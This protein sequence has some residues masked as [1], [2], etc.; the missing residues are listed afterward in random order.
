MGQDAHHRDKN[1]GDGEIRLDNYNKPEYGFARFCYPEE[2]KRILKL[3]YRL[4]HMGR[5]SDGSE[6]FLKIRIQGRYLL[7]LSVQKDQKL[8]AHENFHIDKQEE[9]S[10]H[11]KIL[12]KRAGWNQS[13]EDF[14]MLVR[15][16]RQSYFLA[17]I[18][19]NGI[20]I[21]LG[22]GALIDI[23]E[24]ISWISMVLVHEEVRRQGIAAS[25]MFHC[26]HHARSAAKN[27][28]IGLDATPAGMKLYEQLG[29]IK[30]FP[31]CRCLMPTNERFQLFKETTVESFDKYDSIR[32][33]VHLRGF[34]DRDR[35]FRSLLSLS[36]GGCFLARKKGSITGFVMSRSGAMK[37]YAGPLIADNDQDAALLLGKVLE[38][39]KDHGAD[40][41]FI[42]V[43]YSRFSMLQSDGKEELHSI[44]LPFKV[45]N[46]FLRGGT[47]L[48]I[49]DRMYHV[50]SEKNLETI[51]NFLKQNFPEEDKIASMLD[52]SGK[53][54]ERTIEYIDKEKKEML[55]FQYG[56]GGPEYS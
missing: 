16:G 18:R 34:G 54:Y 56:I 5:K 49:F 40:Q 43:P 35:L 11:I 17:K 32:T 46:G 31:I 6:E 33:Y 7:L 13:D 12:S 9:R 22:S 41:I 37:P 38:H 1:P 10:G 30:S 53:S 27:L 39:W 45:E 8:P 3:G 24:N 29:F 28:I 50:V 52:Q 2:K 15:M 26:L 55:R 20:E 47:V 36:G 14:D 23:G 44:G 4:I 42:D 51:F 21:P 19:L 48:R 25:L